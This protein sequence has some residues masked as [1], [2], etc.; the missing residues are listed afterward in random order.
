MFAPKSAPARGQPGKRSGGGG[1][2]RF[3]KGEREG[4]QG[5]ILAAQAPTEWIGA[6]KLVKIFAQ[7]TWG[8]V[9]G[10]RAYPVGII[11]TGQAQKTTKRLKSSLTMVAHVDNLTPYSIPGRAFQKGE[12]RLPH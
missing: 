8:R 6:V 9:V 10:G 2:N 7:E 1:G 5:G 12:G 11:L 3:R 4:E